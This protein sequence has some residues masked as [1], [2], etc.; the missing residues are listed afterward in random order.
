MNFLKP[1]FTEK[2]V[3]LKVVEFSD[4]IQ[5]NMAL[6]DKS[7]DANFFQH[8]PYLDD[9]MK[10]TTSGSKALCPSSSRRLRSTRRP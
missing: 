2:G 8:K 1:R 4:Y 9:F 3:E 10:H 6:A 7:L 5:P